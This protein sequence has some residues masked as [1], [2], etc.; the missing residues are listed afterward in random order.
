MVKADPKRDYYA[1][2]ELPQGA[3]IIEIK[4]QFKKLALKYHPDRN[5]GKELEYISKFQAIQSAQEVLTDPVQRA[6]YDTDRARQGHGHGYMPSRPGVP[7]RN[8]YQATSNYPPPPSRTHPR[9]AY[10]SGASRYSDVPR[11]ATGKKEDTSSRTSAHTAWE[12]MNKAR[13][14]QPTTAGAAGTAGTAGV[15][16]PPK[17]PTAFDAGRQASQ[18]SSNAP[19]PRSAPPPGVFPEPNGASPGMH[20]AHSTRVPKKAGFAPNTP[21]GDEPSAQRHSSYF[22]NQRPS[23]RP[24]SFRAHTTTTNNPS[25]KNVPP[26]FPARNPRPDPLSQFKAQFEDA[27]GSDSSRLRTPYSTAGGEKTYFSSATLGRSATVRESQPAPTRERHKSVSPPRSR[28]HKAAG[29]AGFRTGP[30]SPSESPSG[31]PPKRTK[32]DAGIHPD[33]QPPMR[34]R[35]RDARFEA[36]VPSD[37]SGGEQVR[38]GDDSDSFI[39]KLARDGRDRAGRRKHHNRVYPNFDVNTHTA[40]LHVP[41]QSPQRGPPR[42]PKSPH[43]P[44]PVSVPGQ[45]GDA[46]SARK[47][48][49]T[50]TYA[51]FELPLTTPFATSADARCE[52]VPFHFPQFTCEE[53][54]KAR[55]WFEWRPSEFN[56]DKRVKSSFTFDI[57]DDTFTPTKPVTSE[58]RAKS[59]ERVNLRFSP[60]DWNGQFSSNGSDYFKAPAPT[61]NARSESRGSSSPVRGRPATRPTSAAQSRPTAADGNTSGPPPSQASDQWTAAATPRQVQFS[62]EYWAQSF[63]GH[64]WEPPPH[65]P[66]SPVRPLNGKRSDP[67]LRTSRTRGMS[68]STKIPPVPK[69]ATVSAPLEESGGESNVVNVAE[70]ERRNASGNAESS[71]MD[72]DSTPPTREAPA[73]GSA[74]RPISISDQPTSSRIPSTFAPVG[75]NPPNATKDHTFT[76]ERAP[77]LAHLGPS[78]P[79]VPP[80]PGSEIQQRRASADQKLNLSHL[81]KVE[82]FAPSQSG[83]KDLKDLSTQLPF[84][85]RASSNPPSTSY[86]PARLALPRVPVAPVPPTKVTQALFEA[87]LIPFKAYMHEWGIFNDKMLGH[88]NDRQ[89]DVRQGMSAHW[90]EII[91]EG[92][93]GGY[94]KYMRG[95]E[96]DFTVRQHWDIAWERHRDAMRAFGVVR[97][98]ILEKKPR[99]A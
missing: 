7:T 66:A 44:V 1:D 37:S 10:P 70:R 95:V 27:H 54:E 61:S 55:L 6:K 8:P 19:P 58:S 88:F 40:N 98:V 92:D 35:S 83:L 49:G 60:S 71:A 91:G 93:R 12:S 21:G 34:H 76:A 67:R 42:S 50:A 84:Q 33:Q 96:E 97:Q 78:G 36:R 80:R 62:A 43:R 77:H 75:P 64:T 5:P 81:Q 65:P 26:P 73:E 57:K 87:Y 94:L 29:M 79:P 46:A 20:R 38:S 99:V 85:S 59:A 41:D 18:G 32:S 22:N 2:L 14:G 3:D 30:N 39:D 82:P 72:I 51:D 23:V 53:I 25:P 45:G 52:N 69:P 31:S 16:S 89:R 90:L 13:R 47:A 68:K 56:A 63:K 4:K 48:D 17:P 11:Y 28:V 9:P 74:K 86:D 24:E 15:R